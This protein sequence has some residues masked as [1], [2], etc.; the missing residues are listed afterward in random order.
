MKWTTSGSF[1][2]F[3]EEL[4]RLIEMWDL[5]KRMHV[6]EHRA[7]IFPP[8]KL[9]GISHPRPQEH[10]GMATLG[11]GLFSPPPAQEGHEEHKGI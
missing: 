8:R 4:E 10:K 3:I 5:P 11:E 7:H 6:H 1:E 2:L 9:F